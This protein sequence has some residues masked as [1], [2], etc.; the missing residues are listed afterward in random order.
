MNEQIRFTI[1]NNILS[2]ITDKYL[3]QFLSSS[4]KGKYSCVFWLVF[5]LWWFTEYCVR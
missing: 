2:S 4:F 5:M 3:C 1:L